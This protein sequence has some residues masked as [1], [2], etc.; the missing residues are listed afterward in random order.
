MEFFTS[1]PQRTLGI[2]LA[3]L[4][5]SVFTAS[6]IKRKKGKEFYTP[7]STQR[8]DGYVGFYGLKGPQV[9]ET[10]GFVNLL[11]ECLWD[12]LSGAIANMQEAQLPTVLDLNDVI[13]EGPV[14]VHPKGHKDSSVHPRNL[15]PDAEAKLRAALDTIKEA[16]V[17]HLVK[18]FTPTDE[19]N[20]PENNAIDAIPE[21]CDLILKV[22]ADYKEL[23]DVGLWI[24]YYYDRPMDHIERFNVVSFNKYKALSG[25]FE[26]GGEYDQLVAKLRPDQR[27]AIFPG[28]TYG[29]EPSYFL[30]A[31]NA[32]SEILAIISFLW[33]QP[34]GDKKAPGIVDMAEM[35][36]KYE[37][38]GRVIVEA[39]KSVL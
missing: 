11:F 25:I 20:L 14:R 26:P 2:V 39:N 16:G 37:S 12:G 28:A 34:H 3:L 38:L 29:Q 8:T 6:V 21:A 23:S 1:N 36:A 7:P 19:P 24:V 17:L 10:K 9:K 5:L 33:R 32:R 35:R 27:T 22:A 15:L 31:M 30:N 13:F 4:F 18:W